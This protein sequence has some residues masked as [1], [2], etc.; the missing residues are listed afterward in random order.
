M[1]V[2]IIAGF[3]NWVDG[4]ASP[5]ACTLALLLHRR[6]TDV[7]VLRALDGL[8]YTRAKHPKHFIYFIILKMFGIGLGIDGEKEES[9][10]MMKRTGTMGE[11]PTFSNRS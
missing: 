2:T 11:L 4:P 8:R 10:L 5:G 7:I 6:N 3:L 9:A 1:L